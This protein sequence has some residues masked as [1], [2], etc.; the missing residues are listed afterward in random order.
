M[1]VVAI[2]V[3]A[4]AVVAVAIARIAVPVRWVAVAI[5]WIAIAVVV[6]AVATVITLGFSGD[7][8]CDQSRS[9]RHQ[10]NFPEHTIPPVTSRPWRDSRPCVAD[11]RLDKL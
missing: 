1:A 4:I 9:R 10:C 11:D 5:A 2:A 7:R 6:V 8:N 3:V